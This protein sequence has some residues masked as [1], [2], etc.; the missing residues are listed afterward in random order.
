MSNPP[1]FQ[2]PDDN[3]PSSNDPQQ[4][5]P[6]QPQYGSPQGD[7][8]SFTPPGGVPQQS[9]PGQPWAPPPAAPGSQQYGAPQS[10]PGQQPGQQWAPPPAGPGQQQYGA[11]QSGPGQQ[12]GASPSGPGQQWAPPPAGS[13]QQYGAP[14]SAPGQQWAPPP[15]AP[16]GQQYGPPPGQQQFAAPEAPPQPGPGG[17]QPYVPPQTGQPQWS[18]GGGGFVDT[19]AAA[20]AAGAAWA[21]SAMPPPS[22][23]PTSPPFAPGD[24]GPGRMPPPAYQAPEPYAP[25]PDSGQYSGPHS[26]PGSSAPYAAPAYAPP[27][28]GRELHLGPPRPRRPKRVRSVLLPSA[29]A[30]VLVAGLAIPAALKQADRDVTG[31]LSD[32][33][34]NGEVQWSIREGRDGP[35]TPKGA[36]LDRTGAWFTGTSVVVAEAQRLVSYELGTGKTLWEYK[37]PDGEF[38]CDVASQSDTKYAVAAF[39]SNKSCTSL[40]AV[41]L[42]T[43][44]KVWSAKAASGEGAEG[45]FEMP[46]SMA[47]LGLAQGIAVSQD[48]VVFDGRAY[49]LSDGKAR[50][51]SAD[52]LPEGC[53]VDEVR[54]GSRLVAKW[55]CGG[56]GGEVNFG[57]L[58][59]A[60]G[61]PK[62]TYSTKA[63][64][65]LNNVE[66]ASVDP[67]IVTEG[68]LMNRNPPKVVVLDDQGKEAYRIEDGH[69]V[70]GLPG[71][72]NATGGAAPVLASDKILYVPGSD[73]SATLKTGGGTANQ[74]TAYERATGKKL[75]TQTIKGMNAMGIKTQGRLYPVR[76]EESGD[77]L[78]LEAGGA[79]PMHLLR[80]SAADGTVTN[81]KE[82]PGKATYATSFMLSATVFEKDGRVTFVGAPYADMSDLRTK[83]I[84][85]KA[86]DSD[87]SFYRLITLG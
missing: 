80:L 74:I 86:V 78:I 59:V 52:V 66:V 37:S 34:A 5:Q 47:G 46:P 50:W 4:Q 64:S 68:D 25:G 81:L 36:P 82:F 12:Y 60:S 79:R 57:D 16:G 56:Y 26:G 70:I 43:G 67:V 77:L 19:P 1:P 69:P 31:G 33:L 53:T 85:G 6:W 84:M 11:P 72:S 2:V 63:S 42:G 20:G 13:G 9:G 45:D 49:G 10:G 61:R 8:L 44:K 29:L 58:D 21:P 87:M 14:Q 62:W 73:M 7:P 28:A 51:N 55:T 24:S 76:V 39:G 40:E 3:E 32:P 17:Q 18:G 15:A 54:G 41:D 38:V 71:S 22:G 23:P 65:A 75:W 35:A 30:A 83:D 27:P 48:V